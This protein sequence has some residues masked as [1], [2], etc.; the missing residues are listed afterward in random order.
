MRSATQHGEPDPEFWRQL[1]TEGHRSL[2]M[3]QWTFRHMPSPPRCKLCYNPFGGVGGRI[4]AVA[5]FR[6]SRK[7]PNFCVRCCE[8]LPLGGADI[9]VAVLFADVRDS[10]RLASGI[11]PAAF[12]AT[13]NRF[14]RD[15]TDVLVAHDAIIDKLVGDEVM[16]LF[17]PGLAGRSY[18]RRAVDAANALLQRVC[19]GDGPH[20][21]VGVGVHA[22]EAYVGNVGSSSIADF[23]AL[24]DTVNIAAR[25]QAVAAP[26]ELVVSD[27]LWQA[28][29]APPGGRPESYALKGK[30]QQFAARV[31]RPVL[32]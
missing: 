9:D 24:G 28:I 29:G 27:S 8:S 11:S 25:L 20:L 23:T 6:P 14:Y 21:D 22:G 15:A 13:L 16:A 31:F 30:D 19:A 1:L 5:G 26:G 4:V 3:L 10:V 18:R 2:A 7:N 32:R 17:I 12:A